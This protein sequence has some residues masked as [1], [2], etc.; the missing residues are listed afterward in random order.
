MKGTSQLKKDPQRKQGSA[1]AMNLI[2]TLMAS[3]LSK[4]SIA[5]SGSP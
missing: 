4:L 2:Y 1:L 5:L 3:A